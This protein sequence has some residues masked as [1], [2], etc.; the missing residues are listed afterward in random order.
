MEDAVKVGGIESA[1]RHARACAFELTA[2]RRLLVEHYGALTI[3][4]NLRL[5]RAQT[6]A[7]ETIVVLER[8]EPEGGEPGT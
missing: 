1:A 5:V 2:L 4:E 3:P 6:E 8:L 7:W